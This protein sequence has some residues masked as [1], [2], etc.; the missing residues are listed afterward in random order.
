MSTDDFPVPDRQTELADAALDW[1]NSTFARTVALKLTP[2]LLP[3]LGAAAVWVQDA[4]GIDMD[5][6]VAAAYVVSVVV[7]LAAVVTVYVRNHGR[8]AAL[9]GQ[10]SLELEKLY[11]AGNRELDLA[12]SAPSAR[13]ELTTFQGS[14]D[15]PTTPP[16]L[17]PRA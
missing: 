15:N 2:V 9:L 5:P 13:G 3:V 16:G 10:A 17:G 1:L 4:I 12:S 6:A 11:E 7:G 8:G 14:G